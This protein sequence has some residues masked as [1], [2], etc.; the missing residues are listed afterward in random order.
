MGHRTGALAAIRDLLFRPAR[1]IADRRDQRRARLVAALAFG[2]GLCV[3]QAVVST[4]IFPPR[5]VGAVVSPTLV[6]TTLLM[7][8]AYA[9]ARTAHFRVGIYLAVSDLLLTP[10]VI[11]SLSRHQPGYQ[12]ELTAV[13]ILPAVIICSALVSVRVA[14]ALGGLVL[15]FLCAGAVFA[16]ALRNGLIFS[17]TFLGSNGLLLFVFGVHR[18]HLE[19]DGAAELLA[20]NHELEAL[21]SDL[22]RR[23][24]ERTA[25][26]RKNYQ[27]MVLAEKMASLGRLTAG[28][29]HEMSS[30]LAAVRANLVAASKL[31]AEYAESIGR[32]GV[33]EADHRAIAREIAEAIADADL[34]TERVCS[35]V[36]SIRAQ[37]R[38]GADQRRVRFDVVS[39]VRDALHLLGHAAVK[40]KSRLQLAS[41]VECAEL[42]GD[43]GRIAQ[44][45]TNLVG[46]AIDANAER[47]GGDVAI[48]V[49]RDAGEIV[50]RVSD[51][52]P[53]IPPENL[54]RIFDPLFTTKPVGKGT[55]LGLSIVH[56][57]VQCDFGGR[58]EVAS[59]RGAGATFTVH[60]PCA[61]A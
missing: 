21:K 56:D 55:G 2:Y 47:G 25:E 29:A 26:L 6:G 60:L 16:P 36:R 8:A 42:V 58:I 20:R 12:P 51:N 59:T 5:G 32:A 45:V 14:A 3:A 52:G 24:E 31:A 7:F 43:P 39:A 1:A 41:R 57:I 4:R 35:F 37:T 18:D 10:I 19:A 22:E 54:G 17:A 9:L 61:G 48:E 15:A 30:P 28:I 13:W 27:T 53:G 49:G 50:V 33:D 34:A 23:V 46:N 38:G 40:D 44:I 11:G